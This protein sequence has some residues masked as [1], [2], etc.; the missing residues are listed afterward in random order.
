MRVNAN[1]NIRKELGIRFTYQMDTEL[2]IIRYL[3]I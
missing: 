3:R 2:I 1:K